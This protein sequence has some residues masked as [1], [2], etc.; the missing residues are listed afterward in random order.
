MQLVGR[1]ANMGTVNANGF[2]VKL[3]AYPN[4]LAGNQMD[5]NNAI[6]CQS[7]TVPSLAAGS[8][9]EV[10]AS[11]LSLREYARLTTPGSSNVFT[12]QMIINSNN[13]DEYSLN[14]T[15]YSHFTLTFDSLMTYVSSNANEVPDAVSIAGKGLN[16][17]AAS[18]GGFMASSQEQ[19]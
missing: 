3:R 10:T 16:L 1:I 5:I 19:N 17:G 14:D 18:V 15:I 4:E 2:S 7:I 9:T 13:N 12:L 6:F 8:F 11:N